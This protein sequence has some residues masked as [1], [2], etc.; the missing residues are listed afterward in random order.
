MQNSGLAIGGSLDNAIVVDNGNI[1]NP[2]GLRSKNEFVK[3]SLDCLGDL[4]LIGMQLN[5]KLSSAT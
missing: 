3:Q 4:Y 1:L 2:E 5:G